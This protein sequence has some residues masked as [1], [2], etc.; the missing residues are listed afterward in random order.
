MKKAL[1]AGLAIIALGMAGC[2]GPRPF[3]AVDL[4][5]DLTPDD[6][7][8]YEREYEAVKGTGHRGA[9]VL[10]NTNWW[11]L[12]ILIYWRRGSVMRSATESGTPFYHVSRAIGLGPVA[13]L[14]VGETTTTYDAAG[15]RLSSVSTGAVGHLG[16][17]H[18]SEAIL[19]N[20]V[21]QKMSS[22]HF[23]HHLINVHNMDGHTNVS[24]ISGPNPIG[25]DFHGAGCH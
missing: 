7:R 8:R 25:V 13:H 20:G 19:P 11:P 17:A 12:G 2:G 1:C 5:R 16:M 21:R 15:K 3:Q 9:T 10:E 24:L 18:R 14:Y 6:L 22:W 4:S 23:L